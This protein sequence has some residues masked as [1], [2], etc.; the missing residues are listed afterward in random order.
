MDN[1]IAEVI[2]AET[3]R[4]AAQCYELYEIPPLGSL[5]RTGDIYAIV[6]G[7]MTT[8]LEPGRKA[9]AR[10]KD[11]AT[12]EAVYESSPQLSRLLRSEVEALVVGYRDGDSIFQYL[13]P[14]PARIHGFVYLC[15]PDEV[16]EFGASFGFLAILVNAALSVP[17]DELIAAALR[18]M[19][20][21]HD[22][23]RAFMVA[24]GKE[25]AV[26]LSSQYDRLKLVLGRLQ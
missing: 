18:R 2:E 5:V 3:T 7:A 6:A 23:P 21:A 9:V 14:Q 4:F 20:L 1:R 22:D 17:S 8:G 16:M 24:A 26:L 10:G 25:L 19:S 15:P 12:E 13:P 11:E